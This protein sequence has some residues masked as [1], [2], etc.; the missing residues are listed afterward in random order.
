MN[1]ISP[2]V[3][4]RPPGYPMQ[5]DLCDA[6]CKRYW[7]PYRGPGSPYIQTISPCHGDLLSPLYLVSEATCR[8]TTY[9]RRRSSVPCSNDSDF[10][11][12]METQEIPKF[13]TH[14][15]QPNDGSKDD[16]NYLS[17]GSVLDFVLKDK[18]SAVL[19][20][21]PSKRTMFDAW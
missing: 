3:P 2:P 11:K 21:V 9:C 18:A 5:F 12:R 10:S 4:L 6:E 20:A 14:P 13:E 16:T 8:Y 1:P 17:Y 15:L 7:P 19:Q